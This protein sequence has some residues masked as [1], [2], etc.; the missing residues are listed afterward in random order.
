[1]A[2]FITFEDIPINIEHIAFVSK[3]ER[4]GKAP[5]IYSFVVI[6]SSDARLPFHYDMNESL[7]YEKRETFLKMLHEPLPDCAKRDLF[8]EI[9]EGFESLNKDQYHYPTVNGL[10]R[11]C[12]IGRLKDNN[13]GTLLL[14]DPPRKSLRCDHCGATE[15]ITY[16]KSP[17]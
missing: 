14:S 10:C 4:I 12:G 16:Q 6:F 11:H 9:E 17:E 8:G 7:A 5:P 13:P 15:Y 2:T 3:V 1:M